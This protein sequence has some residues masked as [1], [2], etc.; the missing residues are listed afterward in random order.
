MWGGLILRVDAVVSVNNGGVNNWRAPS[1]SARRGDHNGTTLENFRFVLQK[2]GRLL[3]D[4]PPSI[5]CAPYSDSNGD[6]HCNIID[7]IMGQL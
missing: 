2:S 1:G 5:R 3:Y 4:E 7:L 6:C